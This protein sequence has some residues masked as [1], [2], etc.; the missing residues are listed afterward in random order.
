MKTLD[1]F[2]MLS[3]RGGNTYVPQEGDEQ[4]PDGAAGEPEKTNNNDDEWVDPADEGIITEPILD[5][6]LM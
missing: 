5:P 4:Y 6:I 1:V 2:E 3:I